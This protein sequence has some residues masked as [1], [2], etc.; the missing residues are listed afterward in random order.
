MYVRMYVCMHVCMYLCMYVYIYNQCV[1]FGFLFVVKIV[2]LGG[3][4][5]SILN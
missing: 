5:S 4:D 1:E 2:H 3:Q